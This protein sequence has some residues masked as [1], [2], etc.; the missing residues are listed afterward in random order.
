VQAVAHCFE[1]AC[2]SDQ[3]HS[4]AIISF[5]APNKHVLAKQMAAFIP[6]VGMIWL[7][8]YDLNHTRPHSLRA[9]GAIQLKLNGVSVSMIQNLGQ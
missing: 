1:Q 6:Q 9:P 3:L 2:T 5:Y 4:N 7:Y 8:G